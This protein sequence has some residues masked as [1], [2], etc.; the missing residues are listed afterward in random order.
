MRQIFQTLICL[1][2]V[3]ACDFTPPI[4]RKIIQ[5]QNFISTQEYKKAAFLYEE[6]LTNNL[7][8][9]LRMKLSYQLGELYSIYLGQYSKAVKNYNEVKILTEDPVWL[10]KV[11]EKISEINFYYLK[12]YSAAINSY[13]KLSEFSPRL[14]DY[15]FF[16]MQIAESYYNQKNYDKAMMA[17][18]RIQTNQ[19]SE[20][21][22]RSFYLLGLIY[23]E[24]KDY[25][26]ALFIWSE[27]LKRE[28]KKDQIVKAKFLVA[29]T[30][31]ATDNLKMAYDIYFSISKDYPNQE[32][33]LSRLKSLYDRRVSRRR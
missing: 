15:D 28:T 3:I 10:I 2:F 27:Y 22:V 30:Y 13:V 24:K 1:I 19:S 23:F 6:I 12:D 11:E 29:N 7:K 14:K 18:E 8:P 5:A 32:V 21:F 25:N 20:Y 31:E 4:N 9:D 16:Q 17:I 33:V 26:K